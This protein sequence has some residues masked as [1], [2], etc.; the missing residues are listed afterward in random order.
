M[1]ESTRDAKL[2]LDLDTTKAV[3]G[4]EEVVRAGEKVERQL[5]KAGQTAEKTT[6]SIASGA[7]AAARTFE[8]FGE[9]ELSKSEMRG[10][11]REERA[12]ERK[13]DSA[14]A[15][16]EQYRLSSHYSR[17]R[18]ER[19]EEAQ[20]RK[21]A[22]SKASEWDELHDDAMKRVEAYRLDNFYKKQR[23]A[24]E[25]LR[26][27]E[28]QAEKDK[29]IAEERHEQERERIVANRL[30]G[31]T[32]AASI[33][34]GQSPLA[35]MGGLGG[36]GVAGAAII[37]AVRHLAQFSGQAMDDSRN[38]S[39]SV[40]Q[41]SLSF[42]NGLTGGYV[43]WSRG[44]SRNM[45]GATAEEAEEERNRLMRDARRESDLRITAVQRANMLSAHHASA[46]AAVARGAEAMPARRFDQSTVR[47]MEAHLEE[48]SRIPPRDAALAAARDADAERRHLRVQN[49]EFG[50][51]RE[52]H[53]FAIRS[54]QAAFAAMELARANPNSTPE[55]HQR[56]AREL[57]DRVNAEQEA[58]RQFIQQAER[59]RDVAVSAL[60]QEVA[61]RRANMD[62]M[63]N[64]ITI[65]Q[66][67][68]ERHE[69][70]TSRIGMMN[71]IQRRL[72]LEA[73][74]AIRDRGFGNVTPEM[75]ANA[76]AFAP[77]FVEQHA[78]RFAET[79][80]EFIAGR[81]EGI[82]GTAGTDNAAQMR[83]NILRLQDG[84]RNEALNVTR[85]LRDG[86]KEIMEEFGL[87]ML[88]TMQE[89]FNKIKAKL[90]AGFAG[91]HHNQQ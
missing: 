17:L 68:L 15:S 44:V 86:M 18:R 72:G 48:Q 6:G 51:A 91:V 33:A 25:E 47:G 61:A 8:R 60:N 89:E 87:V 53:Q 75:R 37:A 77:E 52:G 19:D 4:M 56:A 40:S 62:V 1:A 39:L 3:R 34:G 88:N 90:F 67:R 49:T 13:H 36:R 63:R 76:A 54:R 12:W 23:A 2:R 10:R 78:Q 30:R 80:P 11:R 81:R 38:P 7:A 32:A 73:A 64:E 57:A 82:V 35:L 83:E 66:A 24:R 43:G 14:M 55:E 22:E 42:W 79:T 5:A 21:S 50:R 59:R 16:L 69:S 70:A 28:I 29:L 58:Q 71:P 41:R 74:R 27:K 31:I 45:S 65:Q 26:R 9:G 46:L 84:L 20:R 85:V